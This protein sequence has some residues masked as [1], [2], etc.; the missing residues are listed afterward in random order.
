MSRVNQ[1]P[2]NPPRPSNLPNP[3]S[4]L[5]W[6]V[7]RAGGFLLDGGGMFGLIPRTMWSKWV[8]PDALN[9]IPLA[10]NCVLL[11][12]PVAAAGAPPSAAGAP[13]SAASRTPSPAAVPE[14]ILIE[15]GAGSKWTD[16]ERAM[17]E[18]AREPSG[19]VRTVE[20]ALAEIGVDPATIA[21]VVVTHLHFDHAGGLTRWA[22]S[23]TAA[24]A[25]TH[26]STPA[27]THAA[28]HT[29]YPPIDLVF[30][31]ARVHV[32]RREWLDALA[33]K[34]TMTRTYLRTHL[35]PMAD[36]VVLHD[37]DSEVV[38][39]VRVLPLLGHTWGQQGVV[40]ADEHGTLCYPADVLPTVHH[41]HPAASLGYD[42]LPYDT[43]L[44]KRA[45]LARAEAED[46]RLVLDHEP[47]EC[48]VRARDG[49]L[50]TPA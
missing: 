39:G 9:R 33:N 8:A 25:S 26:A 15:T 45:L 19:A 6:R 24:P 30:P 31:N 11:E 2:P 3:A 18:F 38:P 41:A 36:R 23:A 42:M 43:M 4:T 14:R 46:W 20:H 10:M 44:T 13:P 7:L 16:K 1:V 12:R 21:H 22:S 40:W 27:A 32:Q 50:V 5:T 47:G 48:V 34:S 37:G 29:T 28:T 49:R 17:Y 35:D